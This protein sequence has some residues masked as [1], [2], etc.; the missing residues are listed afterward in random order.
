[1]IRKFYDIE[2]GETVGTSS[3][4]VFDHENKEEQILIECECGNHLLKIVMDA[5]IWEFSDN[6]KKAHQS[7]YLAMFTHLEGKE[8]FFRRIKISFKYLFTG[9]MFRDQLSLTPEE[10][11]K[12]ANFVKETVI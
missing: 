6:S 7:Y 1:M 2:V 3:N 5:D 9:K 8:N 4:P 11:M 12:V 10:A